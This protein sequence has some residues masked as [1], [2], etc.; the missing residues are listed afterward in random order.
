MDRRD[1]IRKVAEELHAFYTRIS[2][3]K[4]FVSYSD[5][6]NDAMQ[7]AHRTPT[8]GQKVLEIGR[9]AVIDHV[10]NMIDEATREEKA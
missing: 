2:S 6:M 7:E 3:H 8:P 9:N 5:V 1:R 10:C 4:D